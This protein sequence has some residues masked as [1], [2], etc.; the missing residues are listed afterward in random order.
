M[1]NTNLQMS[2][3]CLPVTAFGLADGKLKLRIINGIAPYMVELKVNDDTPQNQWDTTGFYRVIE[4]IPAVTGTSDDNC[5]IEN[6]PPGNYTFRIYDGGDPALPPNQGGRQ[7]NLAMTNW[8]AASPPFSTLNGIANALGVPT[9]VH[10]EVGKTIEYGHTVFYGI[11]NGLTPV[12][13]NLKLSSGDYS[14]STF[15]EPATLYHYRMVG[16][17]GNG[18]TYGE[19]LTFTTPAITPIII[20][21]PATNIR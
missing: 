10:F 8:N 13:V 17:N 14:A 1:E 4:N 2:G 16:D 9:N 6:L 5:I 7:M 15:L 19:D 12:N 18:I 3:N 20:T 11:V 21:L